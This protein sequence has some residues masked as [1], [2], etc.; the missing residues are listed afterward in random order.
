MQAFAPQRPQNFGRPGP[1]RRPGGG[2]GARWAVGLT[3]LLAGCSVA[4]QPRDGT[5]ASPARATVERGAGPVGAVPPASEGEAEVSPSDRL[6]ARLKD[7][8]R[9]LYV[10]E[11][12]EGRSAILRELITDPE[13]G[14]RELGFELAQRELSAGNRVGPEV[15]EA[16]LKQLRAE[17]PAT[18]ARAA[19]L[20]SRLAPDDAG[21][22]MASAIARETD[23]EAAAA[24]LRAG[25]RWPERLP[26]DAVV[27]WADPERGTPGAAA[28]AGWALHRVG[29]LTDSASEPLLAALRGAPPE[30]IGAD[31]LRLLVALGTTA[32]RALVSGLLRHPDAPL[33]LAAATAAGS[34]EETTGALIAAAGHDA[35]L[36]QAAV[37]GILRY[38]PGPGGI[39]TILSLPTPNDPARG[40]GLVRAAQEAPVAALIEAAES[41]LVKWSDAELL[42]G[43]LAGGGARA[44]ELT[45]ATRARAGV[46]LAELRL[47]GG[48]PEAAL[49][50]LGTGEPPP[51]LAARAERVRLV[52]L[53]AREL[54]P[55]LVAL[56][57]DE[58][59]VRRAAARAAELMGDPALEGRALTAILVAEREAQGP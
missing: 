15:G 2:V 48:R 17:D 32:D 49:A 23:P 26:I 10:Q 47:E 5:D 51:G 59:A 25:V 20:V 16:A 40:A 42:L 56:A 14:L 3:L 29:R 52:A 31:G 30:A 8:Y 58:A 43:E 57:P 28:E 27:R 36:Y 50:A 1:S 41:G 39:L 37:R 53:V 18:R 7:V 54:W 12:P 46:R 6:R 19:L 45:P 13:A 11:S 55:E 44:A 24:L 4:G 21:E 35:T 34:S 33:R 22:E 38:Q 9:R